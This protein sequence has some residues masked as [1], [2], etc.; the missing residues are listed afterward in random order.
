MV[1]MVSHNNHMISLMWNV[2]LKFTDNSKVVTRWKGAVG[3]L[4]DK[5]AHV[6]G[7]RR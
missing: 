2:K 1:I 3:V 6:Y 5:G 4:K 7:D